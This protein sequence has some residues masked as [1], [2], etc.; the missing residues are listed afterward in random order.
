MSAC[1]ARGHQLLHFEL[2]LGDEF[3]RALVTDGGVFAG[4]GLH[5]GPVHADR[6]HAG[7][8][9]LLGQL[10]HGDEGGL[11]GRP[12]GRAKDADGIVIGMMIGAEVAHRHVA[13]RGR[14]DRARTEPARWRSNISATP[15]SS[16]ADIVRCPYRDG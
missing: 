3:A 14:F 12:V 10:Q 11:E 6:A 8:P 16:W 9:E 7:K 5:L 4:I 15:A 1:S 13:V 2:Q